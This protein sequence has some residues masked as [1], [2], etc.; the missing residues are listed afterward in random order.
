MTKS[1]DFLGCLTCHF[2]IDDAKYA[3]YNKDYNAQEVLDEIESV[4]QER[5]I[6]KRLR[7]MQP[8][9]VSELDYSLERSP[10]PMSP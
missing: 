5:K 1:S 3:V 2:C 9:V 4:F 10:E 6:E 8:E 7:A